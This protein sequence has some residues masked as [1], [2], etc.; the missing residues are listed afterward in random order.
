MSGLCLCAKVAYASKGEAKAAKR[1][2]QR[3]AAA[4]QLRRQER[5][6]YRCQAG[7]WHLAS[8]DHDRWGETA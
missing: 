1:R 5:R 2:C 6:I 4:G 8:S 3:A 7:V